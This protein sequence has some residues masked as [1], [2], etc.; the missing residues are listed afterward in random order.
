MS[1]L[2][3]HEQTKHHFHRFARSLGYLDWASQPDPFRRYAGAPLVDLAR[4]P[5][6]A[7]LPFDLLYQQTPP[8]PLTAVTVAEFLRYS[9]GLSAWKQYG[10]TRW[11]LRV[12]PSSGN[13]HPTEGYVVSAVPGLGAHSASPDASVFHYA[14]REHALERRCVLDGGAW[15]SFAGDAAAVTFLVGLTSIHWREAWKYG[16]RAFRYCQ[17]DAGH[18]IA[19][20]RYA[21]ALL[22]WHM[23]LLPRWSHADVGTILG[24]DAAGTQAEAEEAEC[25]AIVTAGDVRPFLGADP[26]PLVEAA[27]RARWEG[28]PN[29][30]SPEHTADWPVI[31]EAAAATRFPG[32]SVPATTS[33][34]RV[35]ADPASRSPSPS[36]G[37]GEIILRRRSATGYDGQTTLPV[38]V[39]FRMLDRLRGGVPLDA[40]WW[41]PHVN[42]IFFVH[43]VDGLPPGIYAFVRSDLPGFR[44]SCREDLLWE[45][46]SGAKDLYLLAPLDSRA[47]AQRLSCDQAIASE[48]VFAAAMLARTAASLQEYGDWFYRCLFWEC[49]TIGQVLYLEAE[50]AGVRGTGIGC[51]YDD[52]VHDLLG[53]SGHRW[54]SLYHFAMGG[55]VEDTRLTTEPGYPWEGTK[56]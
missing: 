16:E 31:E 11:A 44:A 29:V 6:A 53:L 18:A 51:F 49:G 54:Q 55:H 26:A 50:A 41:T 42:V 43:R 14:P 40:L 21:A 20:L 35:L 12:N 56:G 10:E 23:A 5:V 2:R 47:I 38:G 15:R 13:L 9:L 4:E 52:P 24:T 36:T 33:V 27:S 32:I 17:H 3:Y 25:V 8:R 30:L 22:G 45:P 39:F 1:V 46:I 19:A 48:G 34:R 28:Q 37:A 7:D